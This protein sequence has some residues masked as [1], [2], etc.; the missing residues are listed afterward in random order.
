MFIRNQEDIEKSIGDI[1]YL[2]IPTSSKRQGNLMK[3]NKLAKLLITGALASGCMLGAI[4]LTGCDASS[5]DELT[6]DTGLTG[7]VAGSVN[8]VEIPED[9]ITRAVNNI[10]LNYG[11]TEEDD[12]KNFLKQSNYTVEAMRYTILG[13]YIDEE[14]VKQCADQLGVTVTEEEIDEKVNSMSSQYSSQE[15]WENAVNEV[16]YENGIEGYREELK[17]NILQEKIQKIYNDEATAEME[18]NKNVISAINESISTYDGAKKSSMVLFSSDNEILAKSI[19]KQINDGEITIEEAAKEYSIDSATKDNGGDMGWDSINQQD[20]QYTAILDELDKVGEVSKATSTDNGW[21]IVELKDIYKAPKKV[22]KVS[23]VPEDFVTEIK[24]NA[25]SSN[26]SEKYSDWLSDTKDQ[27]DVVVNPMPDNLP[28]WVDMSGEFTEEEAKEINDDAYKELVG[29]AA[30]EE[31]EAAADE[32]ENQE[33]EASSDSSSA[34]SE[35]GSSAAESAD[36]GES[37]SSDG[38]AASSS[39]E[40]SADGQ[41]GEGEADSSASASE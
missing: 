23:S 38:E 35:D 24:T 29:E 11:Y 15:A 30:A 13:G 8:G 39:A 22:T 12:W 40:S 21:A 20:E 10:R 17:Y 32:N 36:G 33:S 7:G 34:A 25:I 2:K 41:A 19:R 16:G 18:K 1:L 28:Y 26:T 6:S 37:A 4:A 5:S 31:T 27:Q 9:R 14:L 3:L